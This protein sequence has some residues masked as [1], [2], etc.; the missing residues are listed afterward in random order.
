MLLLP[1]LFFGKNLSQVFVD[2]KADTFCIDAD[3]IEAAITKKT[4]AI[5]AVHVFG[6]PCEVEK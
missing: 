2:I 1:Q 6:I 3:K 5:L 4:R